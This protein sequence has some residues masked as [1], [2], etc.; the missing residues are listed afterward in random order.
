MDNAEYTKEVSDLPV[1]QIERSITLE[2]AQIIFNEQAN[3]LK[4]EEAA[5]KMLQN[6]ISRPKIY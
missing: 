6:T 3:L 1:T 2:V 4:Q 5:Q